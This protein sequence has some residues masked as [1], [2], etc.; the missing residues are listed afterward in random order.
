MP[1]HCWSALSLD[2]LE[3]LTALH[4]PGTIVDV[5][6]HDGALTLPLARLPGATV[7]AFEPLPPAFARLAARIG[8]LPIT[9]RRE[10]L[11]AAAG[12][13]ELAVPSVGGVAQE[14]WASLAKDYDAIARSDPRL[15]SIARHLVPVITLDSLN[16]QDVTAMKVDAEGF[17]EQVMR[18]AEA[19]MR[20]CRPVLTVEIEE[21]H[22]P[23]STRDVPAYLATLGYEAWYQLNGAWHPANT[24]DA[25]TFQ[26]ASPSPAEFGGSDPYIFIFLFAPPDRRAELQAL[27]PFA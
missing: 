25:G 5:G 10:A 15:D 22:K 2:E 3:I 6:A 9:L 19:T 20:R 12:T 18:G 8:S 4:R 24:F 7:V 14:Q 13:A 26:V 16:L 17:E 23:G 21:R 27:A 11:G 1:S